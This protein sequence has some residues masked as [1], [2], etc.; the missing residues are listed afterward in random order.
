[1]NKNTFTLETAAAVIN[2]LSGLCH[3]RAFGAGW[4]HDPHTGVELMETLAA[5]Y[6]VAT[7]LALIHSEVSE[8]LEGHRK[9]VMDDKLPHRTMLEVELAD[10]LIRVFDLAGC[11][12]L[13]LGGALQEK[14]AYNADRPD[15]KIVTRRAAGGKLY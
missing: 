1:M 15:H 13:D 5:P 8:A 6:V 3:N 10:V 12:D 2:E 7:K 11:L 14:L 4:W 9:G